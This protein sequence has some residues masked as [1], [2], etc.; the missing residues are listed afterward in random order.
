MDAGNAADNQIVLWR[1]GVF[2]IN[3]DAF[4]RINSYNSVKN[5]WKSIL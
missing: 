3:R 5:V 2:Y 1:Y 4:G